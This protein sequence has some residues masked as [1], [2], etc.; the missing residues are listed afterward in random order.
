MQNHLIML[1]HKGRARNEGR[2]VESSAN[3]TFCMKNILF[4]EQQAQYTWSKKRLTVTRKAFLSCS[5]L[6]VNKFCKKSKL[7]EKKIDRL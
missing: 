5:L 2:F 6:F 7:C 3:M 1:L 4:C